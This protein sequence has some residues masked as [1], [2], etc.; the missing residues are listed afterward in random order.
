MP[1]V[2]EGPRF[3]NCSFLQWFAHAHNTGTERGGGR[4]RLLLRDWLVELY[5]HEVFFSQSYESKGFKWGQ[6]DVFWQM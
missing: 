3:Y 5:N 4:P 1:T 6:I 2:E